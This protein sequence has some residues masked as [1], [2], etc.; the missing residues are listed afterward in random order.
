MDECRLTNVHVPNPP[1]RR[2]MTTSPTSSFIVDYVTI[3]C[4]HINSHK[5]KHANSPWHNY[6]SSFWDPKLPRALSIHKWHH[7][8][9]L[10]VLACFLGSLPLVAVVSFHCSLQHW[11]LLGYV[12]S[13]HFLC[14]PLCRTPGIAFRCKYCTLRPIQWLSTT[15]HQMEVG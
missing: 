6:R 11:A 12:L 9:L 3:M 2:T 10:P 7:P 14:L 4:I 15:H 8:S 1:L 5:Y 13:F